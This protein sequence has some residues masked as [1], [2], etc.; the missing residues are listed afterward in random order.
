[1]SPSS[2]VFNF[3]I[4]RSIPDSLSINAMTT[5]LQTLLTATLPAETDPILQ[6]YIA[7]LVPAMERE[8]GGISA[9]GGSRRLHEHQLRQQ[10]NASQ[11]QDPE[12]I[13]RIR[14]QAQRYSRRPDQ[15]LC[16]HCLN[17]LLI[18]WNLAETLFPLNDSEKR[19][20]C[21]GQTLH[22]Y[23]KYCHAN[24]EGAPKAHEIAD[25][26][27]LCSDLGAKLQFQEFWPD[28]Q[29]ARVDVAFLAQNTQFKCATNPYLREWQEYGDFYLD[30]RRL[31]QL[32][33]LSAL[34]DITVHMK[35]PA[36]VE[37]ESSG[38]RLKD[39]LRGLGSPLQFRYHRLRDT[40]GI[41][42]NA[43]HNTVMTF[44]R[45]QGWQPVAFFAQGVIYLS[46]KQAEV[47]DRDSLKTY[48]WDGMRELL[49]DNMFQGDIG[50]KRDGKGVK[51]APQ[52]LELIPP[53]ELIRG[54]PQVMFAKVQNAKVPATPKRLTKLQQRGDL[55]EAEWSEI[56]AYSDLRADRLAEFLL[57]VQRQFF[58]AIPEFVPWV[59]H[60]WGLA[61]V[62]MP[63]QVE[64]VLGGVNYGWYRLAAHVLARHSGW[65]DDQLQAQLQ[66]LAEA[67]VDWGQRGDRLPPYESP[68]QQ[69]FDR[70]L[71]S[72][73][74]LSGWDSYLGNFAQE[75]DRYSQAKTRQGKQPIC[76]LSSGE[77]PSEDQLDSV[78]LFKPQQYSNK[79]AL[80]GRQIKRGI[81]KIWALEMLLR[82]SRWSASAGRFE[83]EKPVFLYLFPAYVYAPQTIKALRVF[84][85]DVVQTLNLWKVNDAWIKNCSPEKS[86]GESGL[87]RVLYGL[88]WL[89]EESE[90]GRFAQSP[91]CRRYDSGDLPFVATLI[92]KVGKKKTL[93]EAWVI[94]LFL[95][96]ALPR[97]LGIRVSASSS[98]VPLYGSDR[99]FLGAAQIDGAGGFWD[100]LSASVTESHGCIRIQEIDPLLTRLL[101]VYSLHFD[102]RSSPPDPRWQDLK[103]T[104][105]EVISDVLNVF[106]L[107]DSG[108]RA[109]GRDANPAEARRYWFF[110]QQLAQD[111]VLMTEKLSVTK[112]LVT[113]YR[114]FYRVRLTDSSHA[115]LL[116]LTKVLGA[117]LAIPPHLERDDIIQ[118]A[119]GQLKDAIDRQPA[120]TRPLLLDKS[121]DYQIR[122]QQ[123]LEAV[124]EFTTFCVEELFERQYKGDRALLQE[125]RNRIKSGA[126][127]AYRILTLEEQEE[128]QDMD[129]ETS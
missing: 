82:Q 100:L 74:D 64:I 39:H 97:L 101:I 47:P 119:A 72:Y 68:T 99:D 85:Q 123:E 66:D 60:Y 126:E 109:K 27:N 76:T 44:A 57:F 128:N 83:D 35:D 88:N 93:T 31:S 118:Q 92:T 125:N 2:H 110:A 114:R 96:L 86:G 26:L 56:K 10:L 32:R 116:P 103:N 55:S 5:L 90:A 59:I 117:I 36:D 54:L 42:T 121:L 6:A 94:P 87:L 51:V 105:R 21:L 65:D 22:D 91:E 98:H 111:N 122:F 127:F 20:L 89:P 46:P 18:A 1:M 17:G 30:S 45:E 40:I 49:A 48:L 13:A 3:L 9:Q 58:A 95:S 12:A 75:L 61:G 11:A 67:I 38:Q 28:W 4:H 71:D 70:Y 81:S 120:Y 112:E 14:E 108:L 104:V 79:N 106:V 33:D 15:N 113:R 80:G 19:V 63:D 7:Q 115:I 25:I 107:A 129:K 23:N 43:I 53:A 29:I 77:F 84:C 16:V 62:L 34:G 52:A 37:T 124:L 41:L 102:S 50:F 78:V 8:F 69:V 24:G 73:L